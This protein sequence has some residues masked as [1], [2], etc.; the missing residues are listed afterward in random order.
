MKTMFL[1]YL[2]LGVGYMFC[3]V[4]KK[5]DG[6]LKTVGY[7]LGITVMAITLISGA[8]LAHP[9]LEAICCKVMKTCCCLMTGH[10]S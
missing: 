7:T 10:C 1:L 4:A 2:S 9:C 8:M 6:L 3:V 5:Q